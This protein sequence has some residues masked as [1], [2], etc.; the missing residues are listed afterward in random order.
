MFRR[1]LSSELINALRGTAWWTNLCADREL[2]PEIR[3]DAITVYHG[4]AALIRE[5]RLKGGRLVGSVHYKYVP[6]EKPGSVPYID[7]NCDSEN[8][9]QFARSVQPLSLGACEPY[10]LSEYKRRM[11]S[12][13]SS[14]EPE[15]IHQIAR[16]PKNQIVDQEIA[17]RE[18]TESGDK[19]D[20]CHYDVG[21]DALTFV[22]VKGIHGKRLLS[23][24]DSPPGVLTQLRR[25]GER[26]KNNRG[27]ILDA[28]PDV[29]AWKGKLGL[30][31]RISSVP[32]GGPK[33]V[34][35][36]PI[37]VIGNC[38]ESDVKRIKNG[39]EE[40][41]LLMNGI[42]ESAAGLIL[43]GENGCRLD[44]AEGRQSL[45]FI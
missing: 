42:R 13:G 4:G 37:L 23:A 15:I 7:L 21:L 45:K 38:T 27:Q 14:L 9:I 34:I 11:V 39:E 33:T 29:V 36:K 24:Q 20:F 28:Y 18:P 8:G 32:E 19:I 1:N 26:I 17:F 12:N 43:C 31:D 6:T 41:E 25:Y 3:D 44:L 10:T 2:Q 40:W 30:R 5:L 16:N 22:E 35:D